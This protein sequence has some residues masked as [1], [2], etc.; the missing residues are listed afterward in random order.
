MFKAFREYLF[1]RRSGE[2]DARYYL[3]KYPDIR[4][5]DV[6]PLMHYVRHG[7][8]EGRYP[9]ADW[10][11]IVSS[12]N[13]Q[14]ELDSKANPFL[15]YIRHSKGE[16]DAPGPEILRG[17]RF[18]FRFLVPFW[19]KKGLVIYGGYPYPEREKDGYYQ[20]IRAIDS[21]FTDHWRIYIDSVPLKGRSYWYDI[22]EERVLVL[23]PRG[24]G[25]RR[26]SIEFWIRTCILHARIVYFQSVLS[27]SG[28]EFFWGNPRV[29]KVIDVHGA[30]SE[31]FKYQGDMANSQH[32]EQVE[33]FVL[34]RANTIVVVSEAMRNHLV[35]KYPGQMVGEF[36]TIPNIQEIPNEQI[37]KPYVDE[38]PVVVY[39]GGV[40]VWQQIPKIIDAII[41]T[42]R[43]YKFKIFCPYP[44]EILAM[45][46]ADKQDHKV[47]E[48][49]S[50][51]KGEIFEEYRK[52]HY[53]FILRED[54]VV[55]RVSCPTKLVE[56]LA[57]G[58]IPVVDCPEIGDFKSFGMQYVPLEDLLRNRLPAEDTRQKMAQ[59]NYSVYTQILYQY[60]VGVLKLRQ[61]FAQGGNEV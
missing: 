26:L 44:E 10:E 52:A 1:I 31:E 35:N 40:Q 6:N 2:F 51:L 42:F 60:K 15:D 33:G 59:Q 28:K 37:V 21:L 22:P 46:P 39:A 41:R 25:L 27:A 54:R 8:K 36:I 18:L 49:E 3:L 47:I 13:F 32:F 43:L 14:P 7:W 12:G 57:M 58:V 4:R 34:P 38:K 9:C 16:K 24:K 61:A 45:L 53:G 23:R 5:S 11:S 48:V 56:Y 55:N 29:K 30:V 20:R 17:F 50:K 19:F